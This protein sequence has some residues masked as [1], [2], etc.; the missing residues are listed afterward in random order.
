MSSRSVSFHI[1]GLRKVACITCWNW[2]HQLSLVNKGATNKW[3]KKKWQAQSDGLG[4]LL[5]L[6]KWG[7]IAFEF[8]RRLLWSNWDYIFFHLWVEKKNCILGW[9]ISSPWFR[10]SLGIRMLQIHDEVTPMIQF[11][12]KAWVRWCLLSSQRGR[13][14]SVCGQG[15]NVEPRY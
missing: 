14:K 2:R 15:D 9:L 1:K 4:E 7:K 3:Y 6:Y 10:N 5:I 8:F 11:S 13:Q 12:L